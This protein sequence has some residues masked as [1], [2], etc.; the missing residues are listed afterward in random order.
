MLVQDHTRLHNAHQLQ[1]LVGA[2]ASLRAV[3]VHC[4]SV[5]PFAALAST[6][7]HACLGQELPSILRV[8]EESVLGEYAP[9]HA[10]L[11]QESIVLL[12]E[13]EESLLG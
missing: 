10:W 12:S 11:S 4:S 5:E 8:L 9:T 2:A 1:W 6:L 7:H 13:L 3:K